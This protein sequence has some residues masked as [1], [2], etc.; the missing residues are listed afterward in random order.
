MLAGS[1]PC[2][3]VV[4]ELHREG[5]GE[6][7]DLGEGEGEG[8]G[9]GEG[10]GEGEGQGCHRGKGG[11]GEGGGEGGGEGY[12]R[13]EGGERGGGEW[14]LHRIET[15]VCAQRHKHGRTHLGSR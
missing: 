5:G 10:Q 6:E 4:R 13:G 14:R 1:F 7:H 3:R 12:H 9:K 2:V 15:S 11:E 8:E